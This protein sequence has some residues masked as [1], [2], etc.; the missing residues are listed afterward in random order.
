MIPLSLKHQSAIHHSHLDIQS[1]LFETKHWSQWEWGP[2]RTPTQ[3]WDSAEIWQFPFCPR[4][5]A[6]RNTSVK[7][8]YLLDC[9]SLGQWKYT[10]RY[11]IIWWLLRF[12]QWPCQSDPLGP[13]TVRR[14]WFET[15]LQIA[16][17]HR[18][19]ATRVSDVALDLLGV[20]L[21]ELFIT[22]YST[23]LPQPW[24]ECP[25]RYREQA[26]LDSR[27]QSWWLAGNA[28]DYSVLHRL[29]VGYFRSITSIPR[30]NPSLCPWS[31]ISWHNVPQNQRP[32]FLTTLGNDGQY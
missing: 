30:S 32:V 26:A 13:S 21:H 1:S 9:R 12:K 10:H 4:C 29:T 22:F 11:I 6:S 28:V 15:D 31:H 17:V 16:T 24:M 27:L 14:S 23:Y 7:W 3:H 19:L 2:N 8:V 25:V 20:G 18:V 5:E